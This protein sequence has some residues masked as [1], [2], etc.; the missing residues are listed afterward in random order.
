MGLGIPEILGFLYYPLFA[1]MAVLDPIY[2]SRVFNIK[3]SN[4]MGLHLTPDFN[5]DMDS[6]I[7]PFI[8]SLIH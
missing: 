6:F 1:K 3:N 2:G 8:Y 5:M 7:H 4:R